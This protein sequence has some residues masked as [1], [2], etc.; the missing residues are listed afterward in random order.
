MPCNTK[1]L[2]HEAISH[3]RWKGALKTF[4]PTINKDAFEDKTF[5]EIYSIIH[6]MSKDIK[7]IGYL[8]VYD[9]T[10]SLCNYHN[11]P[12]KKVFIIG[13]GPKRAVKILGLKNKCK[14]LKIGKLRL[15]YLELNDVIIA[16]QGRNVRIRK[17]IIHKK[18][19]DLMESYLCNWQKKIITI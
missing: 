19:G 9:I 8:T 17:R 13:N 6:S 14:I 4:L 3:C 18:D 7:G 5:V 10:A 15:K 11:I 1:K 12:I 2:Y 16:L